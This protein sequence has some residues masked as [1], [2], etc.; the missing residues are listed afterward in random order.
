MIRTNR[1]ELLMGAAAAGVATTVPWA[2]RA[3]QRPLTYV[4]WS[5]DEAASKPVLTEMFNAFSA[6]NP[7]VKLEPIG[8]PWAQLQQNLILRPR[9]N[10][11][12]DVA[13]M[14]ERWLPTFAQAGRPADL[15][16]VFG[17]D[18]LESQIDAG[19]LKL[20][21][22]EG[23]QLGLPWT[24]ASIGMVANTKILGDAGI[25]EMPTTVDQFLQALRAVKRTNA[26]SVPYAMMTKNNNSLSPEFQV[27]L[28]T[29]GG[30][31][32][33][34]KGA[35]TVNSDAG[36]QALGLMADL[37]KEG[38]A[39]R[40]IDR[41]DSRRLFAQHRTAFYNDAPLAR[42]FARDNSGEGK[43]FDRNVAAVATPVV[44]AGDA[45]KSLA[46]G[47]L[48]IFPGAPTLNRDAAAVKFASHLA[49]NDDSQLKYFDA[50]GLF[51]VTKTALAK[52]KDDA[53]V[54]GWTRFAGTAEADEPSKWPNQADLVAIIGE[55]V[56]AAVLQSKPA[57][58]AVTDMAGRL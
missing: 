5:H 57:A 43:G 6:A 15:H 13:Q 21:Q 24:A 53:Y 8:F 16:Q 4:G 56:Q 36:R 18:F 3:Q 42:G 14:A 39:A 47:H 1:R 44:K 40:D 32:F 50:V 11:P 12:V 25:R 2:A 58:Q 28:W 48:L 35:V 7:A 23:K 20:G 29:F 9:S 17:K 55:E 22:W 46:W 26:E 10:Q 30:R 52:I 51:P 34:E 33:D 54:A 49:L 27:W 31:L 38:L 19:L 41:P 45:T 37:V